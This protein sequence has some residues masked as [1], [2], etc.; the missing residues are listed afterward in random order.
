[1][2]CWHS[3]YL[4]RLLNSSVVARE[5]CCSLKECSHAHC[6]AVIYLL[7]WHHFGFI[8]IYLVCV[9]SRDQLLLEA[10][11]VCRLLSGCIYQTNK[12]EPISDVKLWSHADNKYIDIIQKWLPEIITS[13][14]VTSNKFNKLPV[15]TT[16]NCSQ[17]L[18]VQASF[19]SCLL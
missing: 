12:N 19:Q 10:S 9:L 4:R 6:S 7:Q 3:R 1:M 15:Q 2:A 5:H 8:N 18:S 16:E 11:S 13:P 14:E 17:G